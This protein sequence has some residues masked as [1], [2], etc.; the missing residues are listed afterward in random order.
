MMLMGSALEHHRTCPCRASLSS[1]LLVAMDEAARAIKK[2]T[3][4]CA[5]RGKHATRSHL[6]RA[7]CHAALGARV[8]CFAR[9][10]RCVTGGPLWVCLCCW[11]GIAE[12]FKELV[13]DNKG[14]ATA[15]SLIQCWM[16]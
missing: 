16:H 12:V 13:A 15:R 4:C 7:P 1:I 2:Q 14:K 9:C 5:F 6:L 3:R 11:S 8:Q 10:K